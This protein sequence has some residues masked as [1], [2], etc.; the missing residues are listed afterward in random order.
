[1]KKRMISITEEQERFLKDN[2][3][4][5]SPIVRDHLDSLMRSKKWKKKKQ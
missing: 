2:Y 5:L 4:K 1:M 3:M